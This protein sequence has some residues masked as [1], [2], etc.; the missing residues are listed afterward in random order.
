MTSTSA[1]T[2]RDVYL[3]DAMTY[4]KGGGEGVAHRTFMLS[5]TRLEKAPF[6]G[7]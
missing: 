4:R 7:A 6:V 5:E 3:S 1:L 2:R